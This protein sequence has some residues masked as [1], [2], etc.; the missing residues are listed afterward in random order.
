MTPVSVLIPAYRPDFL[1]QAIAS[2]L[3]QT[4]Q[5][6]ELLISDDCPD[7]GVK[8]VVA[9]FGD[10]RIRLL[11]GPRQGLVANSAFLFEQSTGEFLKYVYD[12]DFLLPFAI[13]RLGG[14][15]EA[16]PAAAFAFAMRQCV[17]GRGNL[18]PSPSGLKPGPP[19]LY[20]SSDLTDATMSKLYNFVG[21]PINIMMRRSK[22][23]GSDCMRAYAGFELRHMIDVGFY[24][25]ALEHGPGIGLGE[26][27]AVFRRHGTQTTS[28]ANPA[29][30]IGF[31]EW[32][33][34]LRGGLDRG[35]CKPESVI[36]GL[37]VLESRYVRFA[38][39]YPE[40][41]LFRRQ[42]PELRRRI[43]SREGP[44]LDQAFRDTLAEADEVIEARKAG[45][46]A[47]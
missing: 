20:Q 46:P 4:H 41:S 42:L 7:E 43:A 21:E 22:V 24:L 19:R 5:D 25:N 35:R 11:E 34:F 12:D 23:G 14:L 18:L 31:F 27:H 10:R 32:E 45:R 8:Q 39:E 15:L 47:S 28:M 29:L 36:S 26:P 44:L 3:A 38:P 40:L 16:E 1:R 6:Y 30:S 13:A 33:I 17:D 2:V 9:E 37:E